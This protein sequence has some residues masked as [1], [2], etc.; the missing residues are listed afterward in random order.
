MLET[1][2]REDKEESVMQGHSVMLRDSSD[3]KLWSLPSVWPLQH[4]TPWKTSV[5]G[6]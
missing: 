5:N 3:L 6:M 4:S 1:S 2:E